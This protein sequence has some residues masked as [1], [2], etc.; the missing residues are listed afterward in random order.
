MFDKAFFT[1]IDNTLICKQLPNVEDYGVCVGTYHDTHC[2][3][4]KNKNYDRFVE[5]T[6]KISIIPITTRSLASYN[7]LYIKKYFEYAFVE[8]G[9]I[10]VCNDLEESKSWIKESRKI[11]ENDKP[12]FE[13]LNDIILRNG[14]HGKWETEFTIDILF[15]DEMTKQ[16]IVKE[17][18]EL[19][20]SDLDKFLIHVFPRGLICTYQK[21]SKG[22]AIKRFISAKKVHALL[23]AGDNT[24]DVSM[25]SHTTYS[26]GKSEAIFNLQ[27]DDKFEFLDFVMDKACEIVGV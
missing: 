1:D 9:A 3:Y 13:K 23:S 17:I 21:L 16:N 20:K 7:N 26:I 11:I 5:L 4:M 24:Q 2:F 6:K 22:E 12:I 18:Y 15:P 10:L 27:T 8:N 25:F 19:P 14:C